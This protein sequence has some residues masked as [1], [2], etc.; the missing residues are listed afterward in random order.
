MN[1]GRPFPESGNAKTKTPEDL[2]G[3]Y[4]RIALPPDAPQIQIGCTQQA[5]FSGMFAAH[6][7][8]HKILDEPNN[9]ELLDAFNANLYDIMRS[10]ERE[11]MEEIAKTK[12]L[13]S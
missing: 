9:L 6:M 10:Y 11:A 8:V 12:N 2:W 5:F 3:E 4:R 7:Y 13:D 1:L